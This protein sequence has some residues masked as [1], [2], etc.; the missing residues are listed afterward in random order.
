MT[1]EEVQALE[2]GTVLVWVLGPHADDELVEWTGRYIV[3][4]GEFRSRWGARYLEPKQL[5]PATAHDLLVLQGP[6]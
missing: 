1:R 2:V 3:A 4:G 6:A 5:R